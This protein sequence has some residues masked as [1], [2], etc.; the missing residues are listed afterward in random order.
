MRSVKVIAEFMY[1]LK[2]TFI[3]F[4]EAVLLVLCEVTSFFLFFVFGEVCLTLVFHVLFQN[5]FL[6]WIL[7]CLC[8]LQK[9]KKRENNIQNKHLYTAMSCFLA[10][11]WNDIKG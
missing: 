9:K 4:P 10:F 8:T 3:W 7:L 6:S 1:S 11:V 2:K 5:N